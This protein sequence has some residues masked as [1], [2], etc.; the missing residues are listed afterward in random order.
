MK[1]LAL[2]LPLLFAAACAPLDQPGRAGGPDTAGTLLVG[3]KGEDTLSFVALGTGQELVRQPTG[4]M[5]HEI[6]VSPDGAQAAVV[7]YGGN[8]IDVFDLATRARART[9]DL[10]ANRRP[11]GLLWL[12]DGRLLATAEGS[13]TLVVVDTRNRDRITAIS[14]GQPGSH[15]VAVTPD[16]RR[17]FVANIPAGTVT[18]IDLVAGTKLQDIAVGGRPEGIAVTGDGREVWVGDLEGARVQMFDTGSFAR[19]G[20]VAVGPVPIRVIASPD[21]R[22]LVTSNMGDGSI[23]LIDRATRRVIRNIPVSG[24]R[25]AAQV[26]ILFSPNGRRLYAAETGRDQV[27][28]VDVAT[29]TVLRRLPAG[30]Q[31]DGLAI[32]P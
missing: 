2:V 25:E 10:G 4:R 22:T 29:G 17:A 11:H 16:R 28:E 32:A 8:T 23:T 26:T 18:A 6:A 5:P 15:M 20:E 21:G 14:T 30:R 31:G 3:N 7:A 24:S 1:R 19:L 12:P 9:I 13:Q 27:A